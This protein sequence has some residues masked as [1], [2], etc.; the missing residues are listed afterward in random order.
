M[1]AADFEEI[2]QVDRP[3]PYHIT[4]KGTAALRDAELQEFMAF[5]QHRWENHAGTLVCTVCG[6]DRPLQRGPS[7]PSYLAARGRY[8]KS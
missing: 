7:I 2:D 6:L 1:T 5:C 3:I 8:E 4:A